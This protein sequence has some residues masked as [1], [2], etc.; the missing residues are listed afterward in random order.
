VTVSASL[1]SLL[2]CGALHLAQSAGFLARS[3]VAFLLWRGQG[4]A[5]RRYH[6]KPSRRGD[7]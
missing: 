1:D 2:L 3:G 4:Y 6:G 7:H 5:G